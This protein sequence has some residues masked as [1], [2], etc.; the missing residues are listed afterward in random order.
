MLCLN[1][2]DVILL[3]LLVLCGLTG[4][5][6][7]L[8]RTVYSLVSFILALLIT[9]F[10]FNPFAGMLRRTPIFT[11]LTRG[12]SN[13]LNLEEIYGHVGQTLIDIMP[14]HGFIRETLHLN[15]NV[16][17]HNTL[18]VSRLPDYVAAFL[19]NLIIIAVAIL[20][21]FM[22]S[23]I[24]LSFAGAAIDVVG[25]L[26]VINRFNDAGGLLIGLAFG[27]LLIGLVIFVMT[28][29]FSSGTDSFMQNL[30]YGSM[31]VRFLQ[32]TLLPWFFGSIV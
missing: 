9:G 30:L 26:P 17:M 25:K 24:L 31:V 23:L 1:L 5:R 3:T 4:F 21:L 13:A 28:L 12:I 8:L 11:W 29:V 15:N 18:G 7:G 14:V 19:A 10:L 22:I 16:N 20:L 2:F 27:V 32:D 6:R